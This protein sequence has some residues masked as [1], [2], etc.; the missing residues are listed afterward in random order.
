MALIVKSM[1][2]KGY[3]LSSDFSDVYLEVDNKY[4]SKQYIPSLLTKQKIWVTGTFLEVSKIYGEISKEEMDVFQK[5]IVG[6]SAKF[7]LIPGLLV[8]Y[9]KLYLDQ[10]SWIS[11]RDCGI[12]PEEY[13]IKV[14]LEKMI[15]IEPSTE[16][17]QEIELYPHRD[18]VAMGT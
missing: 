4:L 8:P 14:R 3:S 10:A 12:F 6:K 7:F 18:V 2:R 11:L 16:K 17:T 9:D 5:F 1:L 15:A 13:Q